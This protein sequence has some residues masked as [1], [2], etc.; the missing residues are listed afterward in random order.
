MRILCCKNGY[1]VCEKPIGADSEKDMPALIQRELN[2]QSV[3][4]CVHR[5]D[6]AV[7]GV[8]VYALTKECAAALSDRSRSKLARLYLAVACGEIGE[9]CGE[10]KDLLFVDRRQGKTFV[11]KRVRKGVKTASLWFETL[12]VKNG[13]SLAKVRLNTGRTHQVR[14]QFASRAMPLWG[15]GRYGARQNGNVALWSFVLAFDDPG[16]QER[17]CFVCP[18]PETE[19]WT[20]F[21]DHIP[22]AGLSLKLL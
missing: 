2:T 5:L 10:Y 8:M 1:V 3:P 4:Y 20:L 6:Q 22:S 21:S 19:P 17:V 13:L 12:C 9:P 11:V 18:P 15:D 7:G 16:T 14:V